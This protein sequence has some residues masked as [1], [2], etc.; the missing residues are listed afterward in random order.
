L[1]AL[2]RDPTG[3]PMVEAS[4]FSRARFIV[5]KPFGA[6]PALVWLF[7]IEQDGDIVIEYVEEFEGY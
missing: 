6:V 5:T 7:V 4:H 1:D 2:A 3:F